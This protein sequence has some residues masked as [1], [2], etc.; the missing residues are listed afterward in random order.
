MIGRVVDG[1]LQHAG[2][3]V[4]GLDLIDGDDLLDS[5]LV[6]ERIRGCRFVVHLAALDEEPEQRGELDPPSTGG[7]EQILRTNVGGT[8]LLLALA[9][10]AGIERVV[11]LSSVDVLGCF[12]GQGRPAYLP[13][14][15]RHPLDPQGPYAWSKLAGEELVAT[16]TA[17]TGAASV[18]L[19]A[20]GVFAEST[21]AFIRA[22][23]DE[24][25]ESEWE[26]FWE[27]GAFLDVRDLASAI[28]AALTVPRL[29]GHYRLLVNADDISSATEDGPTLARRLL[30]DVPLRPSTRMDQD[31]FAALLETGPAREVLKWEPTH[32]W[33][34]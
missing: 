21:Y 2:F 9:A 3:D 18:C 30:P 32:R 23:R 15:D 13:I 5:H 20:P 27:Y 25:P 6:G 34:S 8:A 7:T 4:V 17:V 1:A 22:A 11:F 12:M 16:F 19:R 26:P 14:D 28:V 24:Q 33:R 31:R 10:E 29:S